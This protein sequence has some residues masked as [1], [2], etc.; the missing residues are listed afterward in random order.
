MLEAGST[1]SYHQWAKQSNSLYSPHQIE[2]SYSEF[3]NQLKDSPSPSIDFV[4]EITDFYSDLAESQQ[5]L[6][7]EFEEIWDAN[8]AYLYES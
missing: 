1:D 5:P 8:A 3:I 4:G 2:S 6:G 7:R